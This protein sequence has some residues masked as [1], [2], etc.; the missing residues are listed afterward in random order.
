MRT[1]GQVHRLDEAGFSSFSEG[2]GS[3]FPGFASSIKAETEWKGIKEKIQTY[4]KQGR[5]LPFSL[6]I[7][8]IT[9]TSGWT[10]YVLGKAQRRKL[11]ICRQPEYRLTQA[12]TKGSF[13]Q[14]QMAWQLNWGGWG[15]GGGR[16]GNASP[17]KPEKPQETPL[18]SGRW[19]NSKVAAQS[20]VWYTEV[21]GS[22]CF[23]L[24]WERETFKTAIMFSCQIPCVPLSLILALFLILLII[25]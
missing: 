13:L 14:V 4:R 25:I 15:W 11:C 6:S 19:V 18:C 1:S 5:N 23:S 16:G 7:L 20:P 12:W 21:N 3:D 8:E 9:A 22:S 10:G 24:W 2:T 17:P